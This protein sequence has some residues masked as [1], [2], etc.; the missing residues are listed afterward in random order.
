MQL[1]MFEEMGFKINRASTIYKRFQLKVMGGF[2][3]AG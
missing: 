3:F 2:S 1:K